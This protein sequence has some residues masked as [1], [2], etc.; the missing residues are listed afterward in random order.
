[1]TIRQI[2][3]TEMLKHKYIPSLLQQSKFT[4]N[5]FGFGFDFNIFWFSVIEGN[6]V[7]H[8][9]YGSPILQPL[10]PFC[11]LADVVRTK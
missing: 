4:I 1:M 11:W 3:E 5:I 2:F 10:S 7:L 9:K 8:Q 6:T